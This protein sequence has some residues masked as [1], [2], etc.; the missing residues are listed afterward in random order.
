MLGHTTIDNRDHIASGNDVRVRS[1]A[2]FEGGD[3]AGWT[4]I[5]L[6]LNNSNGTRTRL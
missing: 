6:Q 3:Q 2:H 1:D 4:R 5:A